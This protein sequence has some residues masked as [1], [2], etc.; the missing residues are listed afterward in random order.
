L[1]LGL[2][3]ACA[4]SAG[5]GVPL[6]E[7]ATDSPSDDGTDSAVPSDGQDEDTATTE[8]DDTG[9]EDD[10]PD[11]IPGSIGTPAASPPGAAFVDELTVQ[12]T[13]DREDGVLLACVAD[14][15]RSCELEPS[16][17][18]LR[19]R[20]SGVLHAR[21]D[22]AG[23]A[24]TPRAWTF[25]EVS[26]DVA[27]FTSNLPVMIA[28]AA[29]PR[30]NLESNTPVGLA[31]FEPDGD[32]T[33]LTTASSSGRARLRIRGS[34]SASLDKKNFDLELWEPDSEKDRPE[35]LLGL[36]E[37]AD[38]VLHAPSY[39]DDALIRN[40]LGYA[41]SNDI[42]RYAPRTRFFELFL[43]D[44]S[45]TVSLS[46]Y[47]G[48]YVLV[49]EIER[50]AD[51]VDVARLGP[52]DVDGTA[53]TG[54]YVFKR[55]RSDETD[56][57]IWAGEAGGAFSFSVPIVPV[58]PESG[59]LADE[60]V[61]YLWDELDSL[62]RALAATD[63]VDP[64]TGRHFED[65][66]D[67]ESLID[68][69]ILNVLFKNPDA[70]RLSAYYHKDREGPVVAGPLWDLDRTAGSRD[71][72]ALDP[73]HWD[74]SNETTDTTP[75]FTYGWQGGLFAHDA[76]RAAYFARWQELLAGPLS[77]ASIQARI[78]AMASELDEAG[79]RNEARWGGRDF[80]GEVDGVRTWFAS[81]TTWIGTCVDT[82]SDPRNCAGE[83]ILDESR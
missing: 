5:T 26:E 32:R 49:E 17:G 33:A 50:G 43:A 29:Q 74:A 63:G 18:S 77:N 44:G 38:W 65:I 21:V 13:S 66:A 30:P 23:I 7:G 52:E 54:G 6:E 75:V 24:G 27:A 60:Q 82:F 59:D 61:D 58:D 9:E 28:W 25:V 57:E 42:G 37:D 2:L 55:D 47:V 79:P 36:P 3:S 15:D 56:V 83:E 78:D 48:L 8:P 22:V 81:R 1:L 39:W 40:A 80:A 20:G 31:V 11:V 72:R 4:P 12:L 14:P 19:L 45:G 53:V 16:D 34:S 64:T 41:L 73:H 46:D 67:L 76:V 51:R 69:H 10:D 68:L 71:A 35:P 70:F 62:G